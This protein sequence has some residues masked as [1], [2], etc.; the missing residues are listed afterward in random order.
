L[1]VLKL[2]AGHFEGLAVMV[3]VKVPYLKF[4]VPIWHTRDG[5]IVGVVVCMLIKPG[6]VNAF[7]MI[8]V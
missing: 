1:Q 8:E 6:W 5:G 7:V 2:Q 3:V 4:V